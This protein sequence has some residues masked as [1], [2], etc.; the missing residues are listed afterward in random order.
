MVLRTW[1]GLFLPVKAR[2]QQARLLD[3]I[4]PNPLPMH[5][6]FPL[7]ALLLSRFLVLGVVFWI[8]LKDEVGIVLT[9]KTSISA[10]PPL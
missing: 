2:F 9:S 8:G 7:F 5:A 4:P 6:T 10:G 3:H 1:S